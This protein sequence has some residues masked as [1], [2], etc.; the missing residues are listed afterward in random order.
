MGASGRYGVALVP[1]TRSTLTTA[2]V[3]TVTAGAPCSDP[4]L[5]A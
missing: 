5:A 1:G 4:W 3:T 2:G